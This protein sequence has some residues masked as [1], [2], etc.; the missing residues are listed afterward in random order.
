MGEGVECTGQANPEGYCGFQFFIVIHSMSHVKG[1]PLGFPLPSCSK[2]EPFHQL[3]PRWLCHPCAHLYTRSFY[4]LQ[5]NAVV[6]HLPVTDR[7]ISLK[8]ELKLCKLRND[9][10][11]SIALHRNCLYQIQVNKNIR[12]K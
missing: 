7:V 8:S 5:R 2:T 9:I 4:C 6:R 3:D 1:F 10:Y 11:S 12:M